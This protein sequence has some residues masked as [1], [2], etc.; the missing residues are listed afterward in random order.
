MKRVAALTFT[1]LSLLTT[2]VAAQPPAFT[3]KLNIRA[4]SNLSNWANQFDFIIGADGLYDVDWL[5][6]VKFYPA[7][8]ILVGDHL[9]DIQAQASLLVRPIG[10]V[11]LLSAWYLAAGPVIRES[12]LLDG[13]LSGVAVD[14]G[15]AHP[16]LEASVAG[17]VL[18]FEPDEFSLSGGCKIR[19][20]TR[21]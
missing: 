2:V 9:P 11:R 17:G 10:G 4:G 1:L 6:P 19:F 15:W 18:D 5:G 20:P 3:E 8:D 13:V 16:Y 7:L 12:R 14:L 21:R